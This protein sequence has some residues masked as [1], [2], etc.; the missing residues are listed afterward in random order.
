MLEFIDMKAHRK[1]H[2]RRN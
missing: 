1:V 2:V